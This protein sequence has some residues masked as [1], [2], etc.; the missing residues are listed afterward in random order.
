M[1]QLI[2]A[3]TGTKSDS[4]MTK[5][6]ENEALKSSTVLYLGIG[7]ELPVDFY[8]CYQD[9]I[10]L[11]GHLY[12]DGEKDEDNYKRIIDFIEA[13]MKTLAKDN[14][15]LVLI[16]GHP[17][18]GVSFVQKMQKYYNN[19]KVL[20]NISSFDAMIVDLKRDPLEKG[21]IVLDV[22]RLL[23]FNYP[24]IPECDTYLYHICSV[25]TS[26]VHKSNPQKENKIG[27][28]KNKLLEFF[29]ESHPCYLLGASEL[30]SEKNLML[31][32]TIGQMVDLLPSIHF[33]TSLFIPGKNPT[34]YNKKYY[35]YLRN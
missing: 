5:E 28:L 29:P 6:I 8:K 14:T 2:I 19:L 13:E 24:L 33:S 16:P 23:L 30:S 35:E 34:D 20:P 7:T 3:G 9:K 31:E 26:R 32:S 27:I 10:K 17:T 11:I 4:Q 12:I 18:F 15:L 22:N 21:S 1:P 25:G